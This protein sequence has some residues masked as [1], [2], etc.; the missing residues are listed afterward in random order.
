MN[1]LTRDVFTAEFSEI[2]HNNDAIII[3]NDILSDESLNILITFPD[4][5]GDT[6]NPTYLSTDGY[7]KQLDSGSVTAISF[8]E[9]YDYYNN[10]HDNDLS[11][12][13]LRVLIFDRNDTIIQDQ[14]IKRQ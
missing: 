8:H 10:I 5:I 11:K 2:T 6:D 4:L 12:L 7:F 9:I 3:S 13:E 14:I 1:S